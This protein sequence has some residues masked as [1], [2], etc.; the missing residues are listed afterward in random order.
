MIVVLYIES[1]TN[2]Y[3]CQ[4]SKPMLTKTATIILGIIQKHPVNAYELIK[5]LSRFQL[6]DWY[7]IADST[8]YA[9][10]KSLEKKQYI[11]GRVQKDGNMPDKTVY[12]LTDAGTKEWET[13]I[14]F[15]LTHFDYDLIPF[16]IASFF[17]ES[18]G[19]DKAIK[20]LEERLEY[21]KKN[22]EGLTKQIEELETEKDVPYYVIGNVQHNALIVETEITVTQQMIAKYKSKA[23]L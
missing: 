22:S 16:M 3:Q 5:M 23:F 21:L 10:L 8:V 4:G 11:T 6:K 1:T 9:T 7:D 15:F 20:C 18:I 13:A 14:K 17:A 12:S 19:V 2:K